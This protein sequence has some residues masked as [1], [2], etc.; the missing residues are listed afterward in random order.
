MKELGNRLKSLQSATKRAAKAMGAAYTSQLKKQFALRKDPYGN[1]WAPHMPS[2]VKRWGRHPLLNLTGD[3]KTSFKV[4]ING[5]QVIAT[6]DSPAGFHQSGTGYMV[7]RP[8]FPS[9]GMSSEDRAGIEAAIWKA[10]G[11]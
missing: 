8:I 9:K 6:M 7:S 10:V 1:P 11:R 4:S 2:T 3:M 5:L